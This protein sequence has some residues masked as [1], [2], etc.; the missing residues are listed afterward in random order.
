MNTGGGPGTI[1]SQV[2]A[3]DFAELGVHNQEKAKK[4][5]E[6]AQFK[7]KAALVESGAASSLDFSAPPKAVKEYNDGIALCA[8]SIHRKP[9]RTCR[10]ASSFIPNLFPH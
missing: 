8:P 1:E 5:Q 9:L 2:A 6:E 4:E 7:A 10:K 3:L